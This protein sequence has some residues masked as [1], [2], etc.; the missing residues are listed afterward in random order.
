METVLRESG[1]HFRKRNETFAEPWL[2]GST[3][4]HR[5]F[6]QKLLFFVIVVVECQLFIVVWFFM[7]V[8]VMHVKIYVIFHFLVK[9]ENFLLVGYYFKCTTKTNFTSLCVKVYVLKCYYLC[10]LF[11]IFTFYFLITYFICLTK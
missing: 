2:W 8:I 3:K 11:E 10:F 6:C 5:R 1:F 4:N 7:L 9:V